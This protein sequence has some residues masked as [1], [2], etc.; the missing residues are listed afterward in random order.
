MLLNDLQNGNPLL[1][2]VKDFNAV[3]FGGEYLI[4]FARNFEAGV[5]VGYYQRTVPSVY[6]NVTHAD[7]RRSRRT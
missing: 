4:G 5:G 7:N 2:E 3:T 1:F 6:A